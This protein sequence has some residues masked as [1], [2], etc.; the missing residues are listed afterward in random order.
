MITVSYVELP[1]CVNGFVTLKD[2]GTYLIVINSILS[3]DDREEAIRHEMAHIRL[4]HLTDHSK[5]VSVCEAEAE[6]F[7]LNAKN[8]PN[9]MF[10]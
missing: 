10:G 6:R 9:C 8:E 5:P 4:G 2:D 1:E 3:E 7:S